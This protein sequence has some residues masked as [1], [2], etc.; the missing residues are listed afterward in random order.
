[1]KINFLTTTNGDKKDVTSTDRSKSI[2]RPKE[3]SDISKKPTQRSSSSHMPRSRPEALPQ[4]Q[5]QNL[6]MNH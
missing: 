1:M 3:I 6:I 2:Q 5:H 4:Y